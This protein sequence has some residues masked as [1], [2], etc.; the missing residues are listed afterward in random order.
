MTVA[1]R[2]DMAFPEIASDLTSIY[3]TSEHY[4]RL[5][6]AKDQKAVREKRRAS[7]VA[8]VE[9]GRKQQ[10]EEEEALAVRQELQAVAEALRWRTFPFEDPKPALLYALHG[11]KE[12]LYGHDSLDLFRMAEQHRRSGQSVGKALNAMQ[13]KE[14][15][16]VVAAAS[17][18]VHAGLCFRTG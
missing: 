9:C 17:L 18:L 5:R 15:R 2:Q 11:G 7:R 6:S 13:F 12:K 4:T 14:A 8:L 10:A 16:N 3:G 1:V